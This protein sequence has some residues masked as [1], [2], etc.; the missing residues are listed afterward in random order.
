MNRVWTSV[1]GRAE[2]VSATMMASRI[3]VAAAALLAVAAGPID[4]SRFD[5]DCRFPSRHQSAGSA[6]V[7]APRRPPNDLLSRHFPADFAG[8]DAAAS[9]EQKV[10]A[11]DDSASETKSGYCCR[12]PPRLPQRL[13]LRGG[14]VSGTTVF[15]NVPAA[16]DP[17]KHLLN[18]R[19]WT[20]ARKGRVNELEPLVAAGAQI[21][22][23]F[24][25]D[26]AL[27]RGT[28][29]I[30]AVMGGHQECVEELARL[31]CDM[32]GTDERQNVGLHLAA[33]R[34]DMG[35]VRLLVMLGCD[36]R[37][38][39]CMANKPSDLAKK[40]GRTEVEDWLL[41]QEADIERRVQVQPITWESRDSEE[42]N[43][44]SDHRT[45]VQADFFPRKEMYDDARRVMRDWDGDQEKAEESAEIR[46]LAKKVYDS[47]ESDGW[48]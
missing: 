30:F 1:E 44:L 13:V 40:W 36:V 47:S 29:L 32:M 43:S 28:A 11:R 21:N 4:V 37:S 14:D 31:G 7:L 35:M 9:P 45:G 3:I 41:E 39:N 18:L 23:S 10:A 5:A 42:T 16:E 46:E 2:G 12:R 25:R 34:G 15:G 24:A 19:L 27:M 22:A 6:Q 33:E 20:A 48:G 8:I 26:D 38:I 17:A